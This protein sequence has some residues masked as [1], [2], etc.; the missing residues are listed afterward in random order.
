[1]NMNIRELHEQFCDERLY[2]KKYSLY[3][4]RWYQVC[5]KHQEHIKELS[6]VTTESLREFL[7]NGLLNRK[8]TPET[9]IFHHKSLRSF[10]KWCIGRGYM[11]E[12]PTAD[13]ESPKK[14]K[15]LP[16]CITKQEASQILDWAFG[17]NYEYHYEAYRNRALFAIMI[18]AGLRANEVL[19][20]KVTDVDFENKIITINRGKGGKD[21]I[22]PMCVG[23]RSILEKYVEDKR[24]L[25]KDSMYFFTSL[26][27]N[28]QFTYRV[29]ARMV[30]RIRKKSGIYFTCHRLRHTFATL[31]LEGGCDLY[32]LSKM[33]GHS[34]IKTTT[35]YLSASV[36]HMKEQI[37][38]HP[39]N[40]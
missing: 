33:M 8:W 2:I 21:R 25:K 6:Q 38:K 12:D 11:E 14:E 19:N 23:L 28:Q 5:L 36:T 4:I 40:L 24:R 18:Y 20:L 31:M 7:Y 15:K 32:T 30:E 27:G 3:T 26:R 16:K 34:D 39:L 29:L 9:F 35:I 13:I 17:L 1:M 10:F 37:V 22:V